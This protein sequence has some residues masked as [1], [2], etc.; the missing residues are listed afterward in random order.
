MA[1]SL[2]FEGLNILQE[3]LVDKMVLKMMKEAHNL[4]L[5]LEGVGMSHADIAILS[6][7]V[8]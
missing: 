1:P 6:K 8:H 3:Q 2:S 5:E 4:E 7:L